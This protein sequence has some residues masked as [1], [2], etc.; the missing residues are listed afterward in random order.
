MISHLVAGNTVHANIL[1][2]ILYF[3]WADDSHLGAHTQ[4]PLNVYELCRLH[5]T[6]R[7][8]KQMIEINLIYPSDDHIRQCTVLLETE[9]KVLK[10]EKHTDK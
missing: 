9:P 6:A 1:I 2:I 4:H 7:I 3:S 10:R 5:S 8:G